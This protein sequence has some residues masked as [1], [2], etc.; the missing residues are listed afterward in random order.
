MGWMENLKSQNPAKGFDKG[1]LYLEREKF[2]K[3]LKWTQKKNDFINL[4]SEFKMTKFG[5]STTIFSTQT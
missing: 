5:E 2:P 4:K 1:C 3:Y